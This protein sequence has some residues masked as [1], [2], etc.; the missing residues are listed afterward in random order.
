MTEA[1]HHRRIEEIEAKADKA[2][3]CIVLAQPLPEPEH[4]AKD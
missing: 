3:C 4:T 2:G 1:E